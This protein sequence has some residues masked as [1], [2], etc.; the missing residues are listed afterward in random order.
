MTT[1]AG[2][3]D[4]AERCR[5]IAP[6]A[7]AEAGTARAA[8]LRDDS[9]CE[10]VVSG[11][12]AAPREWLALCDEHGAAMGSRFRKMIDGEIVAAR[13]REAAEAKAAEQIEEPVKAEPL[14]SSSDGDD[15]D[16]SRPATE[17]IAI[18][19]PLTDL[20]NARLLVD[21]DGEDF[22]WCGAMPGAGWL[23]WEGSRWVCDDTKRITRSAAQLGDYWRTAA[24]NAERA[25]DEPLA[26]AIRKHVARSESAAGIRATIELAAS[27]ASIVLRRDAFDANDWLL[28]TPEATYDLEHLVLHEP[29]RGDHITKIAGVNSGPP[30]SECP[31]W[32]K[33]LRRVMGGDEEMV[34]FLQRMV[35]YCLTG[36]TREQCMFILYGRGANGKSTFM[37]ILQ[38]LMGDYAKQTPTET[39]AGRREGGI[40]NDLAALVGARLVTCS[41]ASEDA[42]LEEALV[43]L[44]TG[45]DPI[46]ARFL[47]REF[48]SY[49]PA[50]KLMM[51]TN[52][53]PI[54]RGTDEGIWRRLRLIPFEVSIPK[55]EQDEHLLSKLKAEGP[56]IMR[57]AI[58]GLKAWHRT[59][60]APPSA[61]T[62]ATDEYR[63]DM[64]VLAEFIADR[65]E[66]GDS[67]E[68]GNTP[69]Y[70]AY[71]SWAIDNGQKPRSHKWLTR[72][73]KDRGFKQAE[74]HGDGRSWLGI[75]IVERPKQSGQVGKDRFQEINY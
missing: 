75:G 36:S 73:L 35:G 64:D 42:G 65:C 3:L 44:A 31:L 69:L 15:D 66:V 12:A 63:K 7:K 57:W 9:L 14:P 37:S 49:V 43:K 4:L 74:R 51:L 41:E 33:F 71:K 61:V 60:L 62:S 53:K 68:A 21:R 2:L 19:Y 59:G 58:E 29:R 25:D 55:S 26:K 47:N 67:E 40:P 24:R 8:L 45:G 52:H 72:K 48:F 28:N 16:T 10:G 18:A 38:Y 50:F 32:L 27:E 6:L 11:G 46:T 17:E 30:G 1:P 20:G 54:I 56:A 5:A 13:R 34:V 39:F 23:S 70:A 22:R